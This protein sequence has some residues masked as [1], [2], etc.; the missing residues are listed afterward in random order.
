[1]ASSDSSDMKNFLNQFAAGTPG[2]A[3]PPRNGALGE[4]DSIPEDYDVNHLD[5]HWIEEVATI[6]D[7]KEIE[8]LLNVLR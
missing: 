8:D 5:Y 3:A 6:K 4:V 2:S 1:M 7:V